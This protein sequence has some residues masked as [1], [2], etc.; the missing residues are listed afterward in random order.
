[1]H[2]IYSGT[3]LLNKTA[4]VNAIAGNITI[5]GGT[6]ELGAANQIADASAIDLNG[7][8]FS[9]G[10]GAGS[11]EDA[12]GTLT[13]SS[14][15]TIALGT[16]VHSLNFADSS[17]IA[18]T[19]TLNITGW[20]GTGG[21]GGSSTAGGVYIGGGATLTAAQLAQISFAGFGAGAVQLASGEILP[22]GAIPEPSTWWGG[23]G[24][25]S[26][27]LWHRWRRRKKIRGP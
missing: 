20:T 9:S 27:V 15:S 23:G 6:V 4:G 19:G 3:V 1:M 13:L 11:S 25:L 5:N 17:A 10:S 12:M 22:G 2:T 21:A 16:G 14:T 7:G 18:W 8:T 24:L 26:L